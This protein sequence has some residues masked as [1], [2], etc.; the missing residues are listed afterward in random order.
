ML[1]TEISRLSEFNYRLYNIT[2]CLNIHVQVL[3]G[4][5][6]KIRKNQYF[7]RSETVYL[8]CPATVETTLNTRVIISQNP[9]EK[10][11]NKQPPG[12]SHGRVVHSFQ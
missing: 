6:A 4:R 11:N 5:G 1:V 9:V 8:S 7:Q 2:F 10:K 12:I 3:R